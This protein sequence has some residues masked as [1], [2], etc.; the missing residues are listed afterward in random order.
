MKFLSNELLSLV[1][2]ERQRENKKNQDKV[3]EM[4]RD[5]KREES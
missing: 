3:Q 4:Q 5:G 1:K 2:S